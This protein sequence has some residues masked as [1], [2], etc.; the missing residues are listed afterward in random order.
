MHEWVSGEAGLA[1]AAGTS[2]ELEG[3]N[4]FAAAHKD[5]DVTLLRSASAPPGG[6][7]AGSLFTSWLNEVE[8]GLR[9]GRFDAVYLSLHGACQAEGDPSADLTVLR[10]VR[11]I[12]GPLPV[13]ASFDM[14]ANLS[15]EVAIL[16]DGATSNRL[17]DAASSVEAAERALG[18]LKQ[19]LD[20]EIRPV[21]ALARLAMIHTG[22]A[23]DDAVR[24]TIAA[25]MA[26][27]RVVEA[28]VFTGFAWG[29][30]PSAGPSALV[31][32][33]RDAG[34]AREEAAR[35]AVALSRNPPAPRP[36]LPTSE[37][38]IQIG[39]VMAKPGLPALV[40]DAGDDP[41][42]GG[43]LDTPEMLR[44]LQRT[45]AFGHLQDRVLFAALCDP[46]TV[47][48][49]QKAGLGSVFSGQFGGLATPA[50]GAPVPVMGEIHKTGRTACGIDYV[51][52]RSG[53][54]D[55]LVVNRRPAMIDPAF[56]AACEI[57]VGDV[58]LLAIK[59]A[60]TTAQAFD[61]LISRVVYA[62]CAGPSDTDLLRLSYHFVPLV[63]RTV[64][65]D[66]AEGVD[67]KPA[68]EQ[69]RRVADRRASAH[70]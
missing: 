57:A 12:M 64:P 42:S 34:A 32:T 49:A 46:E 52:I 19:I 66:E 17:G 5:W 54:I 1:R 40:L 28:S 68:S 31:W 41:V 67:A 20:G 30:S 9:R 55:V 59:G 35:L 61:G 13:V 27:P 29:D 10:R 15:E 39:T 63:R 2:S 6:P 58:Q 38:A 47:V 45:Q 56:L 7:L 24:E 16:L 69:R 8:S 70:L 14:R 21:G 37:A 62:D 53:F 50:Y 23:F 44:G 51:I 48:A 11:A 25:P 65:E 18:L 33:D 26:S 22:A 36:P 3:V 4:R 43:I 60:H